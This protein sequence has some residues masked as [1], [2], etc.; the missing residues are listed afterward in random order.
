MDP[1]VLEEPRSTSPVVANPLPPVESAGA[2][3]DVSVAHPDGTAHSR[4][5]KNRPALK[6]EPMTRVGLAE[7]FSVGPGPAADGHPA[8]RAWVEKKTADRFARSGVYR[9]WSL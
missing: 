3:C 4:T 7:E 9:T 6:E 5:A 2:S 1:S 8:A